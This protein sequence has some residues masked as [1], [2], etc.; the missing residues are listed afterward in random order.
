MPDF[1]LELL[2]LSD[3]RMVFEWRN[4]PE[5]V[6]L[7]S[8]QKIV[9]WEEHEAW[10]K[11]SINNPGRQVYIMYSKNTAVGQVR[12]E[13]IEASKNAAISVY[14]L[15]E[16]TGTGLGVAGI[17]LGV[18]TIFSLW[19][20]LWEIYAFVREDNIPSQKAFHKS[21]FKPAENNRNEVE[22]HVIYTIKNER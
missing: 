16:Y 17:K 15:H 1:H 3:A 8:S 21:G 6:R 18:Q 10:I 11:N 2:R 5:I 22:D 19:N 20:D 13:R 4:K 7:S 14:L 12:F 9:L